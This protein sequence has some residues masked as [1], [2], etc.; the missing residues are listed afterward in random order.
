[1][2]ESTRFGPNAGS[3]DAGDPAR[4]STRGKNSWVASVGLLTTQPL[5]GTSPVHGGCRTP[6]VLESDGARRRGRDFLCSV[7][8]RRAHVQTATIRFLG[9]AEKCRRRGPPAFAV[10]NLR[11]ASTAATT[12]DRTEQPPLA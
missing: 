4:F 10:G 11:A 1:M 2:Q 7:R 5:V 3:P 8:R 6:V 9:P 12:L